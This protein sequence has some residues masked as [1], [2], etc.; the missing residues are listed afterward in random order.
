MRPRIT[1]APAIHANR[2]MARHGIDAPPAVMICDAASVAM[3]CDA[4][5]PGMLCDAA[6]AVGVAFGEVVS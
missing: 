6:S 1:V 2:A 3:L 4:A 5:S